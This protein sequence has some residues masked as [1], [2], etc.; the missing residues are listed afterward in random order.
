MIMVNL[1]LVHVFYRLAI[2][3]A[4]AA[5]AIIARNFKVDL[6]C[7]PSDIKRIVEFTAKP[8]QLP[9]MLQPRD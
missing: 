6:A 7:D 3:E 2:M 5:L 9:L 4:D 8:S 1:I